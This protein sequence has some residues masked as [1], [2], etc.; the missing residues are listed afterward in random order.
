MSS[1]TIMEP[2]YKKSKEYFGSLGD[3]ESDW[4]DNTMSEF[5][6]GTEYLEWLER[7]LPYLEEFEASD[8]VHY[9]FFRSWSKHTLYFPEM[10]PLIASFF[11]SFYNLLDAYIS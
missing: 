3:S 9:Y 2:K 8:A 6:D 10:E 5:K 4:V 7:Q 11:S 1:E